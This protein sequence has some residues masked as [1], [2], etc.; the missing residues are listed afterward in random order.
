LDTATADPSIIQQSI[1]RLESLVT[2][3]RRLGFQAN[4][5]AV[6]DRIPHLHVQNPREGSMLQDNVY[7]A[8]RGDSWAYWWSWA[9]PVVPRDDAAEAAAKIV[10]VLRARDDD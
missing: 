2:P 5:V 8:P 7:A 4:L 6:V 10:Q 9:E 3:L 1:E